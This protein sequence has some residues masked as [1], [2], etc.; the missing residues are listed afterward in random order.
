MQKLEQNGYVAKVPHEDVKT[1]K[2]SWYFPHH[3]VSRNSKDRIVFNCSF[4]YKGQSLN[5]QLLPG[6]T[7]GPSLLGVLLRFRQRPV[8]VSGDIKSMFHQVRLLP[9]GMLLRFNLAYTAP[10]DLTM[11]PRLLNE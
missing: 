6:L 3:A 8:A 2:E 9:R 4:N 1:S 11:K 7:L 10:A 5:S